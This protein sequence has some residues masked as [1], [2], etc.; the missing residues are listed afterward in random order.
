MMLK[1]IMSIVLVGVL[2][3]YSSS[4][5]SVPPCRD[6]TSIC[7][8]DIANP[9]K[10]ETL[11]ETP[12]AV[13]VVDRGMIEKYN[14]SSISAAVEK[15]VGIQVYRTYFKQ[16]IATARG[17][18]QDQYANKVLV[19]IN[20]V[21]SWH[22]VTGEGNLDRVN[23]HDV[24]RIE[25]LRG[26]AS[27]VYG[28][29]AYT[30]AINIVLR[31]LKSDSPETKDFHGKFH[32]GIGDKGAYSVGAHHYNAKK[33][34][35]SLFAALNKER[36]NRYNYNYTDEDGVEDPIDDYQ[37][38]LNASLSF[39]YDEHSVL[40]NAFR[41]NEGY[42]GVAPKFARGAGYSHDV[43]GIIMGYTYS[44][45]WNKS[46]HTKLQL[47]YDLNQRKFSRS[48]DNDKR[49]DVLGYR[50]G[51][52]LRNVFSIA[53]NLNLEFGGDYEHRKSQEYPTF[54]RSTN[55]IDDNNLSNR[56]M[57]EYSGYAQVD[58]TPL[59]AWKLVLG[60][61]LTRNEIFGNNVSSRGTLAYSVNKNN[62]I[63]FIAGQSFRTPSFFELYFRTPD[64]TTAVG[65]D[66]LE[67]EKADTLELAYQYAEKNFY[68]QALAYHSIYKNK[69]HRVNQDW[70]FDDGTSV[71]DANV[72]INGQEFTA[73]GLEIELKYLNSKFA[74]LFLNLDYV[75]GSDGDRQPGT[76]H[77]NFKY[78]PELTASGGI[79]RSFGNFDVSFIGNYIGS[80]NG[81]QKEID[82]AVIFDLNLGYQHKYKNL[83]L[84]HVV[85]IYNLSD[86]LATFPEYVRH[87]EKG[88]NEMPIEY[89]RSIFY[90]LVA[91][92]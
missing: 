53:D 27:V 5:F 16:Q 22:A 43:E 36:G 64:S 19:M 18:L 15:I 10:S 75:Y 91:N 11:S 52:N 31:N 26:P 29:Q 84:R 25:V 88:V 23:I 4:S 66:D 50:V 46:Y 2:L 12:A 3:S 79:H 65:N 83:Q 45:A 90:S 35:L 9:L 47:F 42:F 14:F 89:E 41:N 81:P 39:E 20:G 54:E 63:K 38:N 62:T 71:N 33:D 13:T 82:D 24:E 86:T 28:S 59:S 78:V 49:S 69:I 17:V 80:T 77:Y 8:V 70:K 60:S 76:E 67:P 61:R 1:N 56:T 40:I 37:D 68:L 87:K 32:A 51:G 6:W 85:S 48:F 58:W 34:G 57:Y 74:D 21:P 73:D 30:G 7:K 72:Y 92:F 44:H 55:K